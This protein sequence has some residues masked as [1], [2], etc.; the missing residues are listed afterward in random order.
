MELWGSGW[1][2]EV[3]NIGHAPTANLQPIPAIKDNIDSLTIQL[4]TA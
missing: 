3:L 2:R 4:A 1:S